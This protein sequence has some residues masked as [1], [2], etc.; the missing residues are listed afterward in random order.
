MHV[1]CAVI[2]GVGIAPHQSHQALPAVYPPGILHQQFQKIVLLG[3]Q[4]DG[5]AIPDGHPLL[6]VQTQVAYRQQRPVHLRPARAALQERPDAGLQLQNVEGLGHIV[7]RAAGKAHQLVGILAAGRQHD[8]G[9]VG[10]LPDLH[11]GLGARQHRHHQIE[12]NQVE[13]LLLR[14][15]HGGF[16]IVGG[17]DLIALVGQIERNAL[18]QQLLVVHH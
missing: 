1:H 7:V 18:Y 14:Q 3:G 2:S 10:K 13:I 5:L 4:V 12:N 15:L 6:G 16:A 8:D 17:S 11:A 9:H